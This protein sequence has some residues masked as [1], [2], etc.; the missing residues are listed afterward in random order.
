MVNTAENQVV[1]WAKKFSTYA[2]AYSNVIYDSGSNYTVTASAGTGGTISPIGN[3]SVT[4]GSSK[5]F[6]VTAKDGYVV[7]DVLVDGKSVGA[8]GSYTF[9]NVTASHTIS[10]VFIKSERLPYYLDSSGNKVFIGFAED[11]SGEM[12]YIAPEGTAV[13]FTPNPKSFAD[14]SGHW[15]KSYID[16]VTEREIFI[17]TGNNIFSPD[18]GMGHSQF[19]KIPVSLERQKRLIQEQIWEIENGLEELKD[20]GAEQFTI[21]QL[22]RTKKGLEARL[23]RLNDNSRKDDVV[24]F[25]QLGV[26]RLFVDEAHNYKNLFLY[27]KMRNVAGLSTTDA[28]KSSDMMQRRCPPSSA[29]RRLTA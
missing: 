7:S 14:I 11:T 28:Q 12:K 17:G 15:G 25:E 24:T 1:V 29:F 2:I 9:T 20:S 4:T 21:K 19:E 26:D 27:T 13:L 23:K 5:T 10:A 16:F 22:E 3:I 6:T 18:T 8:V